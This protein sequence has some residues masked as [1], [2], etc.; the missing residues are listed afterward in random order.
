MFF[1]IE[2]VV[3]YKQVLS[4]LVCRIEFQTSHS[5][6][7]CHCALSNSI[8]YL[9]FMWPCIVLNI[10]VIKPTGC[11][12]FSILFLEWN[13][14]CFGQFLC[15]SSGVFHCT[16]SKPVSRSICSCSQAVRKP[17]WHITLL[18]V[19]WENPDD[20]ERNRPKQVEFHSKNK[21]LEISASSS[22][23]YK[24]M[25]SKHLYLHRPQRRSEQRML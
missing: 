11:T 8:V 7:V 14:T 23:Y 15:P 22:F 10:L 3:T 2:N 6:H 17:V 4:I 5:R 18:C 25:N 20:G 13:S 16:H 21:I 12:N 19:Q 1:S 24:K 9:T